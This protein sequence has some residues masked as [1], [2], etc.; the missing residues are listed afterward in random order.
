MMP[1]YRT[2]CGLIDPAIAPSVARKDLT[3]AYRTYHP[4][5][6]LYNNQF[7]GWFGAMLKEPWFL[8]NYQH[9]AEIEQPGYLTL[10]VYK[11]ISE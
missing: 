6:I 9:S 3:W 7:A 1:A 2:H 11:R 8:Q 10:V 4:D 5:Y